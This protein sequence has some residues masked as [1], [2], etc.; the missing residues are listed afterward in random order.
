VTEPRLIVEVRWGKLGGTKLVL[1]PGQTAR[2]GRTPSADLIIEHDGR[3]S[4]EHFALAWDGTTATLRYLASLTGTLLEGKAIEGE[5]VVKHGGW[6]QAGDTHFMVY[7]EDRTP[8]ARR[9]TDGAEAAR[10][11]QQRREAAQKALAELRAEAAA[12]PLYALLD[13]ARD[14]RILELLREHVEPHRSLYDGAPGE[15]LEEVAPYLAGPMRADS[16]L[17]DRLV[18]EGWGRRWGMW[19]ASG[20]PFVE[21]RR[22]WRRFLLAEIEDSGQK[23]YFRF[24]DPG[25][26]R[27]FW[28]AC[29]VGQKAALF[30]RARSWFLEQASGEVARIGGVDGHA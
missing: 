6:V 25:V 11:E 5:A 17:L 14:D 7:V 13:A 16:A 2:V 9:E 23:V 20:E 18:L 26:M 28:G 22:H 10:L 12:E 4:R 21:V 24:Y 1:R 29:E 3:M 19:C 15:D 30:G 27:A 8:A